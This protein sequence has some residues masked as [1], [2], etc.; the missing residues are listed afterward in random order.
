MYSGKI[1]DYVDDAIAVTVV[2]SGTG[3]A[4]YLTYITGQIP[5]F[6]MMGFGMILAHFFEKSKKV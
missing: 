4:V 6:F 1:T 2:L 3:C 5:E